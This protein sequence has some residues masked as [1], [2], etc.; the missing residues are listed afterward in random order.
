[1]DYAKHTGPCGID[2][3][4]CELHEANADTD[5]RRAVNERVPQLVGVT[6]KGCREQGGCVLSLA[7]CAT[8]ECA[9]DKGV[10]FCFE[11]AEFPCER[12]NPTADG[13]S[14]YPHNL[15]IFNLCRMKA[16]GI[17]AWAKEAAAIRTRYFKG[18]FRLG[19]APLTD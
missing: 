8:R 15:K 19:D 16:V 3:F 6:C 9:Q 17:D 1:M 18:T 10:S 2:C 14:R 11:C 7:P 13:A 5:A 4:N 12:L